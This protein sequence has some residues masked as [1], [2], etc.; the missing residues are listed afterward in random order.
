MDKVK[1]QFSKLKTRQCGTYTFDDANVPSITVNLN[2]MTVSDGDILATEL[3]KYGQAYKGWLPALY[4]ITGSCWLCRKWV[5]YVDGVI[6]PR[7]WSSSRSSRSWDSTTQKKIPLK[8]IVIC[9][10]SPPLLL[11]MALFVKSTQQ[12]V[13]VQEPFVWYI[14]HYD[15]SKW[16]VVIPVTVLISEQSSSIPD[17]LQSHSTPSVC[18]GTIM[19]MNTKR[20]QEK[21]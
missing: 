11:T 20:S 5:W 16:E 21:K 19:C 18:S 17:I 14:D 13:I 3:N 15:H 2:D 7:S 8:L 12:T 1:N 6:V 4:P 9:R 10:N